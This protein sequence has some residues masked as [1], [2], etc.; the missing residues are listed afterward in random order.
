[1]RKGAVAFTEHLLEVSPLAT[2]ILL[3]RKKVVISE[4]TVPTGAQIRRMDTFDFRFVQERQSQEK[5][6][7][8]GR[9]H[10]RRGS[11]RKEG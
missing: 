8:T 4:W 6:F 9:L 7:S 10:G 11:S 3:V 1:M 5:S 2:S